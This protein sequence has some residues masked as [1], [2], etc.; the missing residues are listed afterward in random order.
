MRVNDL[1]SGEP[2]MASYKAI[3]ESAYHLCDDPSGGI[4]CA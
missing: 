2:T 3:L 4:L 1:F